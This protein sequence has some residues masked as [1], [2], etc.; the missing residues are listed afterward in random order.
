MIIIFLFVSVFSCDM[1]HRKKSNTPSEKRVV[2]Q[3]LESSTKK[4]KV[5]DSTTQGRE[6]NNVQEI[7]KDWYLDNPHCSKRMDSLDYGI[8][9]S[10]FVRMY[11]DSPFSE[12]YKDD[13]AMYRTYNIDTYILYIRWRGDVYAY[14]KTTG[15]FFLVWSDN[16]RTLNDKM[17][18]YIGEGSIRIVYYEMGDTT[19]AVVYDLKT[20]KYHFES[21]KNKYRGYQF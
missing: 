8:I 15:K 11:D 17:I 6:N 21:I 4:E 3:E 20:H 5:S 16:L 7:V 13:E 14:D 10:L 12:D 1:K 18:E 19:D 2:I 9:H